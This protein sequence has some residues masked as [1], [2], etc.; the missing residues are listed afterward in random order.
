VQIEQLIVPLGDDA[1]GVFEESDDDE[2]AANGGQVSVMGVLAD[3]IRVGRIASSPK[4][5]A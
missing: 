2:E 4:R 5:T 3:V 1:E